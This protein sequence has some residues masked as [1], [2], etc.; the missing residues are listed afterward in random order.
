MDVDTRH[1]VVR[2]K[3]PKWTSSGHVYMHV[4]IIPVQL[5]AE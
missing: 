1:L 2:S 4:G 3:H 5:E